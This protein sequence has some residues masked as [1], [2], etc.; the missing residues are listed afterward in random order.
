MVN[1]G[2]VPLIMDRCRTARREPNLS[3]HPAQQ[4][5]TKVRRQ[6]PTLEIGTDSLSI[7]RRKTGCVPPFTHDVFSP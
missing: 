1:I 7:D 4:E 6:G 2:L 5:C 3:V